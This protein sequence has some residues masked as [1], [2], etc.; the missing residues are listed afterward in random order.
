MTSIVVG[1]SRTERGK[2]QYHL[3]QIELGSRR[4]HVM[5]ADV[6]VPTA[7]DSA[8]CDGCRLRN[9]CPLLMK[10]MAALAAASMVD[11]MSFN[12]LA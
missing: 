10:P 9:A 6:L 5:L 1:R 3:R 11:T 2:E 7:E 8:E 12:G 4:Y